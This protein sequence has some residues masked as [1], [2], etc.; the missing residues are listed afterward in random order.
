MVEYGQFTK[1][2]DITDLEKFVSVTLK[3]GWYL[4]GG[5]LTGPT[6]KFL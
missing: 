6:L 5:F 2:G 1:F 4:Q 3:I